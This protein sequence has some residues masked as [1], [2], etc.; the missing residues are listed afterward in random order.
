MAAYL[1]PD[2]PSWSISSARLRLFLAPAASSA[3]LADNICAKSTLNA[4]M[5]STRTL[6]SLSLKREM[7]TGAVERYRPAKISFRVPIRACKSLAADRRIF[8]ESSSSS[9]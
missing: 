4:A 3:I 7:R 1:S 6:S 9:A 8:Q 5:T 2:A